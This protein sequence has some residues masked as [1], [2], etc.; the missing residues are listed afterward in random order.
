M[1]KAA[2]TSRTTSA[3]R[4]TQAFGR[5]HCGG[6]ANLVCTRFGGNVGRGERLDK[7]WAFSHNRIPCSLIPGNRFAIAAIRTR[8]CIR[9]KSASRN[10]CTVGQPH[11]SHT[12]VGCYVP[13]ALRLSFK[14]FRK[15]IGWISFSVFS[16]QHLGAN[17]SDDNINTKPLSQC[18]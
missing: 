8:R 17:R 13:H 5:H 6:L 9:A 3:L 4:R 10:D 14:V 1:R 11:E 16:V 15:R 7:D 18:R 12:H 2:Q